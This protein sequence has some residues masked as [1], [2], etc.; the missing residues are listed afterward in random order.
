MS[1]S[2]DETSLRLKKEFAYGTK[3][4]RR[5]T[6]VL[7]WIFLLEFIVINVKKKVSEDV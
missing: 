1:S 6:S 5:A 3:K 2:A 7:L 4:C